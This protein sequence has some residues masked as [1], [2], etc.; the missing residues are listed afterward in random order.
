[1]SYKFPREVNFDER[2]TLFC[3]LASVYENEFN[4]SD[5]YTRKEDIEFAMIYPK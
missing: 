5:N 4:I 1:M 2:V 3:R